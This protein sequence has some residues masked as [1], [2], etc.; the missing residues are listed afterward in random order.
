M[1]SQD[2][3][4]AASDPDHPSKRIKLSDSSAPT[5]DDTVKDSK[6]PTDTKLP[7]DSKLLVA[8]GPPI[9][10]SA[11]QTSNVTP[12]HTPRASPGA[13][14]NYAVNGSKPAVSG[15]SSAVPSALP[16]VKLEDIATAQQQN[17]RSSS[18]SQAALNGKPMPSNG[19]K[20]PIPT[21]QNGPSTPTSAGASSIPARSSSM[22]TTHTSRYVYPAAATPMMSRTP[23]AG[24]GICNPTS[25][26]S[27]PF[28]SSIPQRVHQPQGVGT[29][30]G[31]QGRFIP[32]L[33]G[34]RTPGTPN[35][36][37]SAASGIMSGRSIM[38]TQAT[39]NR[40]SP[41]SA[42][43]PSSATPLK[44]GPTLSSR[45]ATPGQNYPI[46][47]QPIVV[48]PRRKRPLEDER[49]I[50][51]SERFLKRMI[52]MD[53]K[54]TT[55]NFISEEPFRNAYDVVDRLL[56]FHVWQ[57]HDE[58]LD[59]QQKT[60]ARKVTERQQIVQMVSKKI[61]LERRIRALRVRGDENQH[62]LGYVQVHNLLIP[63]L[64]DVQARGQ[65][66]LRN[67]QMENERIVHDYRRRNADML[68]Q[69]EEARR[70]AEAAAKRNMPDVKPVIQQPPARP[71]N[72]APPPEPAGLPMQPTNMT[73]RPT[74]WT[75]VNTSK[76]V[77]IRVP[78][79][80][81][82]QLTGLNIIR[83]PGAGNPPSA[84]LPLPPA[85]IVRTSEDLSHIVI[86]VNLTAVN[87][88]QL[89]F[90]AEL[91]KQQGSSGTSTP[92]RI[93]SNHTPIRPVSA[94]ERQ[95]QPPTQSAGPTPSG[96][97]TILGVPQ[98]ASASANVASPVTPSLAIPKTEN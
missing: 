88:S 87:A 72:V 9:Q 83:A 11:P 7:V 14:S 15:P 74:P 90:L 13:S 19:S 73:P 2:D 81:L 71:L 45:P 61:E 85:T 10:H 47:P 37:F 68:R 86:S 32:P 3:A 67:A 40:A 56:P 60:T 26:P 39:P 63:D 49:T 33:T 64:K 79:H 46:N 4:A 96:G 41:L 97:P 25:Q 57:V 16:R 54:A 6:P 58:D 75:P 66:V 62:N 30:Q 12:S 43:M 98:G 48:L 70:L 59:I 38:N 51:E 42:G 23:S 1:Q 91:V 5:A 82:P 80:M 28:P 78:M 29:P 76:P 92:N 65:G 17:S 50:V 24:Q 69:N 20:A 84:A 93:T 21:Y 27:T 35:T 52:E 55:Q 77:D 22:L 18:S 94:T 8:D 31:Q 95:A 53:Q 36:A 44:N 89:A 34:L